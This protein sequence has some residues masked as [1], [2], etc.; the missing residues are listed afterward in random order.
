[1][2]SS[3]ITTGTS[4]L[5]PRARLIKTIGE[6]LISSDIVAILE[7]VKNSY[8]ADASIIIISFSGQVREIQEGK[9]IKRILSKEGGTIS[10]TDDGIGMSLDTIQN[11]WMEPAT[12]MKKNLKQSLGKGRRHTGEKGIGR[13]ASAKLAAKLEILTREDNNDEVIVKFNWQDFADD[14]KYL[15]Q[16]KCDWEVRPAKA[17]KKH[18]T[19]LLLSELNSDWDEDKFRTLKTTL[20]RL[21]NPV[22]P[23]PDFLM[24][25]NLPDLLED[26]GGDIGSP[27]SLSTPFYSISGNVDNSGTA[28][29]KYKSI[30]KNETED[31]KINVCKE[32]RPIRNIQTGPFSFTFNVWDRETE[33]L[34]KMASG[35]GSTVQTV[36]QD[37]NALGGISIYRD[38]FRVLPYGEP[39]N[40]WLRLDLRRVQTPTLRI[41]NN[42]IIGYIS[43][44]LNN[45]PD[46]KDQSN[47]EG[48]VESQAFTDL[49]DI[50]KAILSQLEIRRYSERRVDDV[51]IPQK[52]LF[53]NFNVSEHLQTISKRYP[54]DKL[55]EDAIFKTEKS[56]EEGVKKTQEVLARYRRLASL[57]MLID[58]VLHDGNNLLALLDG[59]VLLLGRE[60]KKQPHNI[61]NIINFLANIKEHKNLISQLFKRL[62]PL[63]GRRRGKPKDLVLED[64]IKNAFELHKSELQRLNINYQIPSTKNLLKIDEGELQLILLNLLQNSIYWLEVQNDVKREIIVQ[65]SKNEEELILIFS[66][67]GPGIEEGKQEIIFDPYIS[68]KPDGIGIGLTIIG[69]LVAEHNGDLSLLDNGPLEGATFKLTFRT[70]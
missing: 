52:S 1:M 17:I 40:D 56:L 36:K 22:S 31:F 18:G 27:T 70:T 37:L 55:I 4:I 11:A 46:F 69:E 63:G 61:E 68:T 26:L 8:D 53:S 9:T 44:S 57:G 60:L 39:K 10:I 3:T 58:S 41:S 14:E 51:S 62:E 66:D 19:A 47:R 48:L 50:I 25:L 15:D 7:L 32:I 42:Q 35:V 30:N 49:Q 43:L 5:R 45:N 28:Y 38:N 34:K 13:F 65:T 12:I 64:S 16:V 6:E 29:L 67:S 33:V 2:S 20:S 24:E 23:V 21:I 54:D 59:E